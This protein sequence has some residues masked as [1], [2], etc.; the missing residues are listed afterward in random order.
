M[1]KYMMWIHSM[2]D[3][4]GVNYGHLGSDDEPETVES[5]GIDVAFFFGNPSTLPEDQP[6]PDCLDGVPVKITV[7]DWE[8]VTIPGN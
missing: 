1:Y 7:R 5:I 8:W 3:S 2:P 6:I 4:R